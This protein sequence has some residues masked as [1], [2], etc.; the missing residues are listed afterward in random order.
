MRG[1]KGQQEIAGFIIIVVM[2]V[3][4]MMI[5]VVISLRQ[6]TDEIQ[7][8]TAENALA[9]ILSYTTECVVSPPFV[10]SVR[11]LIK[12]CYDN[13]KCDNFGVMSC[14]YL[15]STLTGMLP[16]LLIKS[17]S[18]IKAYDI[19]ITWEDETGAELPRQDLKISNGR[20]NQ[21]NS[22][23]TGASEIVNVD[24]GVMK[25]KLTLCSEI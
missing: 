16:E 15:N 8:R 6:K 9:S 10:Q 23:V 11:D 12:S 1:R 2:V 13:E 4:A 17:E 18:T 22:L 19:V 25:V 3:I 7:S 24:S 20:C 14:A 21:S 5:F